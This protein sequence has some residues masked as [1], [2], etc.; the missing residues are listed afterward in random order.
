M[1][2]SQIIDNFYNGNTKTQVISP[3]ECPKCE[4]FTLIE[5]DGLIVCGDCHTDFGGVMSTAPEWRSGTDDHNQAGLDQNRCGLS[6]NPLTYESSFST[7]FGAGGGNQYSKFRQIH[8]WNSMTSHERMLRDMFE[9]LNQYG[10]IAGLSQNITEYAHQLYAEVDKYQ[11]HVDEKG[12]RGANRDGLLISCLY[13]SCL[14]HGVTRSPAELASLFGINESDLTMG[15]NLFFELMKSSKYIN[16]R[17]FISTYIDFIDRF[18]N[19]LNLSPKVSQHVKDLADTVNKLKILSKNT[20]ESMVCACIL[21]IATKY[22]LNLPKSQIHQACGISVPTM[23]KSHEKLLFYT[24]ML[25]DP[26]AN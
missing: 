25:C 9:Q 11:H 26:I 19:R 7:S 14:E 4:A 10:K 23:T 22:R 21:Y 5:H 24:T 6:A 18:C 16:L 17:K 8:K 20:P 2:I 15:N 13:H 3:L 12:S 1:N